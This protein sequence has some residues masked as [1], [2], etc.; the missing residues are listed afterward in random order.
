MPHL[1]DAFERFHILVYKYNSAMI[2]A[3]NNM[4]GSVNEYPGGLFLAVSRVAMT[5]K[6]PQPITYQYLA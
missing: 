1:E 2:N 3:K 6:K 5:S 4:M